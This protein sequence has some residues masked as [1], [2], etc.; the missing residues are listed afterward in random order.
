MKKHLLILLIFVATLIGCGKSEPPPSP[1]FNTVL[2]LPQLMNWVL[3]PAADGIWNAI[4][5]VSTT[6][7]EKVI[8]P[9]TEAEWEALRNSAATLMEASNLLMLE[10][11]A[12]DNQQW[13]I[14]SRNLSKAAEK[15]LLAV[16]AKDVDAIFAVGAEI[17]NACESCHI[18]YAKFDE[19]ASKNT[20]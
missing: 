9:H 17:E 5:W 10:G 2:T 14:S 15:T 4:S 12:K 18:Q 6:K 3:D 7:G 19:K 11:R 13:M 8:A 1:P 20:K 16:Q